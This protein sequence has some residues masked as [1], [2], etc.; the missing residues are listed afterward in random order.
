MMQKASIC[1]WNGMYLNI[2]NNLL[3]LIYVF[4]TNLHGNLGT[5]MV[6]IFN[7]I[8]TLHAEKSVERVEPNI[9]S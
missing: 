4:L 2:K 9:L 7:L 5:Y 6:L 1:F 8:K 3:N